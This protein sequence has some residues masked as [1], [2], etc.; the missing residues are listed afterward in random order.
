LNFPKNA[1]IV[2]Q[3]NP[4]VVDK[5][6]ENVVQRL[7]VSCHSADTL[8]CRLDS[9]STSLERYLSTIYQPTFDEMRVFNVERNLSTFDEMRDRSAE[10]HFSTVYQP[11]IDEMRD[12]TRRIVDSVTSAVHMLSLID[13]DDNV[14]SDRNV[15]RDRNI[16]RNERRNSSSMS[17]PILPDPSEVDLTLAVDENARQK[18]FDESVRQKMIESLEQQLEEKDKVIEDQHQVLQ[19]YRTEIFRLRDPRR[20]GSAPKTG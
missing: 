9:V 5:T 4:V 17:V 13:I 10:R 6:F 7:S 3:C 12:L 8:R 1:E 14:E 15:E 16:E 2:L 20:M 11:T 18:L 19:E